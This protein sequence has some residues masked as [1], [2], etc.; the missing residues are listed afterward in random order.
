MRMKDK[1]QSTKITNAQ[2][3]AK[4]L[5]TQSAVRKKMQDDK[6]T[7]GKIKEELD[8]VMKLGRWF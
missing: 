6:V 5:S 3:M 1:I 7:P 8:K 2:Q 4:L